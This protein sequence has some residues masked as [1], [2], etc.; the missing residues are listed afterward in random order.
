MKNVKQFHLLRRKSVWLAWCLGAVAWLPMVVWAQDCG[1][2]EARSLPA[3]FEILQQSQPAGSEL[4]DRRTGLIWKRCV[5]GMGWDG[6]GCTG[7][8][9]KFN[10]AQSSDR[11][12][13]ALYSAVQ[14]AA[15]W[16]LPTREE[17]QSLIVP[18]CKQPAIDA[19][20]FPQQP[21]DYPFNVAWT[22]S[23]STQGSSAW[24]LET[25]LGF[26]SQDDKNR[27]YG[28]RLVRTSK[29]STP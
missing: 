16:R 8:A 25:S 11:A 28:L 26:F 13:V 19:A 27:A 10:W 18:G 3:H 15:P 6:K 2:K 29:P 20:A 7:Q 21:T 23:Q 14:P 24:A 9:S 1:G 22:S 5:E 17:L 4:L 12:R